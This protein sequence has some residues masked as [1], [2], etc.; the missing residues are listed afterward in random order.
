MGSDEDVDEAGYGHIAGWGI[1]KE[2]GGVD[3][4]KGD[5]G[6]PFV[7]VDQNRPKIAGIVSWGRGCARKGTPSVYTRV[8]PYVG[9][10]NWSIDRMNGA[11]ACQN[12]KDIYKSAPEVMYACDPVTALCELSCANGAKPN[13]PT[14]RCQYADSERERRGANKRNGIKKKKQTTDVL[15]G[16]TNNYDHFCKVEIDELK[17]GDPVQYYLAQALPFNCNKE[18]QTRCEVACMTGEASNEF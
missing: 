11:V 7:V 5:S 2:N 12:P 17:C 6:G 15:T 13:V 8:A 9:W 10:I 1:T 4:C 14:V 16:R 18:L 3:A